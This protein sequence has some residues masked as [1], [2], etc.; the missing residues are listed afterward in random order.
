MAWGMDMRMLWWRIAWGRSAEGGLQRLRAAVM[1]RLY[2]QHCFHIPL[3]VR[4]T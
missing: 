3:F 2:R 4:N 1:R